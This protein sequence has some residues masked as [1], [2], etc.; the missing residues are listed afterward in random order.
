MSRLS[1][2]RRNILIVDD[3]QGVRDVLCDVLGVYYNCLAV[4]SAE[5]AL[6]NLDGKQLIISDI[7][8]N[9]MS[10]F[11][12]LQL[13][14]ERAPET[15]FL[16]ISGLETMESSLEALR[17]GAFDYL[18]KPFDLDDIEAAVKRAFEHHDRRNAKPHILSREEFQPA[19]AC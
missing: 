15:V 8:M 11:A 12:L 14:L 19:L 7:T 6:A 16:M 13:A 10:G 9:G 3:E 17:L 2:G 1:D 18:M 5:E 4:S